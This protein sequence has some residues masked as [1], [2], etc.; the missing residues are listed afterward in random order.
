MKVCLIN[1][2]IIQSSAQNPTV[3]PQLEMAYIAAVL[4]KHHD[5][6]IIDTVAESWKTVEQIETGCDEKKYRGGL[7]NEE[8][9]GRITHCMPDVVVIQV[10]YDG[11]VQAGFEIASLV[12]KVDDKITTVFEGLFPSTRQVE[13]L[14]N[15]NID[16]V[17]RGEPEYTILEL[18]NV[19]EKGNSG[20]LEKVRGI[21]YVKDGEVID[22]PLR[23]GI[24]NLDLLP[25]PARRLLPMD[26]YF[27]ASTESP[28]GMGRLHKR[29]TPMLTSRGCPQACIFC[30]YHIMMGRKWRGRS[31]EN[32]LCEIEQLIGT[33]DIKQ[34]NFSDINMSH[35]RKRM[36]AICDRMIE[37]NFN[38]EWLVPQGL[39]ADTLDETLLK[40]MSKAGCRGF[41]V[42]PESG[43]Q[44]VVDRIKK[45]MDLKAVENAV[46]LASKEGIDTRAYFI[47]GFPGETKEDMKKTIEFAYKLKRL[48]AKHF[49]F[50]IAT[51]IFGTELYELA[52][53]EGL[54][55]ENGGDGI[56]DNVYPSIETEEFTAAYIQDICLQAN[57]SM[58]RAEKV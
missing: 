30:F 41:C 53:R 33:Y 15:R 13:C 22:N 37:R 21:S 3:Y 46:A 45:N 10:M 12:K 51:P 54:L 25:F 29:Y 50:N 11:R 56:P 43:V 57:K 6:T 17:V 55:K 58:N 14:S 2:P 28:L 48:G 18:V 16:F 5:V 23:P 9:T 49:L 35:D 1:P 42:A 44:R 27:E 26:A 20:N 34:I 8:I 38:I 32:V 4:E 52:R 39:R 19:L 31:P 36:E 24:D 47:L 40:K 7:T